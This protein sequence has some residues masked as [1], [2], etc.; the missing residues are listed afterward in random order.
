MTW[1]NL[2]EFFLNF[3]RILS[4]KFWYQFYQSDYFQHTKFSLRFLIIFKT[5]RIFRCRGAKIFRSYLIEHS[6]GT[7]CSTSRHTGF[8]RKSSTIMENSKISFCEWKHVLEGLSAS[9]RMSLENR[10]IFHTFSSSSEIVNILT[11]T[12]ISFSKPQGMKTF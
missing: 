10:S 12:G 1:P 4:L 11:T 8:I 7:D 5:H 9:L 2:S 3:S 6:A